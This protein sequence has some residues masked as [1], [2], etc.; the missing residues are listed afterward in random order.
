MFEVTIPVLNEQIT[1]ETNVIRALKYIKMEVTRDFKIVIAD[2][3]STDCTGEI[4]QSLA[5]RYGE[6]EYIRIPKKGVGLALRTSWMQSN[7]EIVGY[8]DLDLATDLKHLKEVYQILKEGEFKIV[9]GSR[10]MKGS[11]VEKRTMLRE[12]TSR[13]F[14]VIVQNLLGVKLTDGMCG[15]KFFNQSLVTSLINTGIKTDGWFFSTEVLVKAM[16]MGIKIRE[17]PVHWTD[18]LNS[19]VN[20]Y[21]LS[22]QYFNEILRLRKEKKQFLQL[23]R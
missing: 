4:G 13:C 17:I 21:H 11:I 14:N 8:M 5:Q 15:F 6:I 1:L 12:F 9:N 23:Q 2:N 16:W 7:A 3:G 22:K 10:L 20:V 19:K 18:D